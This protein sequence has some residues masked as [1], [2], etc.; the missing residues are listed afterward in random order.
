M[1]AFDD[2]SLQKVGRGKLTSV[3]LIVNVTC[4]CL[5]GFSG[6][7]VARRIHAVDGEGSEL[8][9]RGRQEHG[10]CDSPLCGRSESKWIVLCLLD[11]L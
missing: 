11:H 2:P 4:L 7:V 6:S 5:R 9:A 10:A 3:L 8:F 1:N